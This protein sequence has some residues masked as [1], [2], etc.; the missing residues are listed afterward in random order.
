MSFMVKL[1]AGMLLAAYR[2]GVPHKP[3][4]PGERF[5]DK[6]VAPI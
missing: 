3:A 5:F 6:R 1:R 2:F 4:N